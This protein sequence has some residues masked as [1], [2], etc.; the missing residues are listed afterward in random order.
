[1]TIPDAIFLSFVE[2]ITEFLPISST[3]HLLLAARLL[4]IPQT[5]FVKTFEI[6]IQFGAI[7]AVILLYFQKLTQNS[8]LW[9]YIILAFIPSGILGFLLYR[10]IKQTF[11]TNLLI[12]ISALIIGGIVL[13]VFE[14]WKKNEQSKTIEQLSMIDAIVIGIG[15][16][17]A[18]IPGVSRSAASIIA[19]MLVGLSKKD[20]VEFSFLLA[21]PTIAIASVF[22]FSQSYK[23][24]NTEDFILLGIGFFTSFFFAVIAIRFFLR[25]VNRQSL[26]FFGVYRIILGIIF[27]LFVI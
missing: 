9:K 7:C 15:Q 22:D 27:F 13:I 17:L 26:T 6:C 14:Q 8:R 3:G 16:S 4:N 1:M 24:L 10:I 18:V 11:F 25:I 23:T 21:V 19:G 12:T 20:A 5:E 2:G